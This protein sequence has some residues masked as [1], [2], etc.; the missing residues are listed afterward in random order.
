VSVGYSPKDIPSQVQKVQRPPPTLFHSASS[1]GRRR[2]SIFSPPINE[3]ISFKQVPPFPR[4]WEKTPLP[5]S[6]YLLRSSDL[7]GFLISAYDVLQAFSFSVTF[8]PFFPTP[9]SMPLS[10]FRRLNTGVGLTSAPFVAS[11]YSRRRQP[12][13]P[14][15]L[16]S[17]SHRKKVVSS[18]PS[19]PR[20]GTFLPI[21]VRWLPFFPL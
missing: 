15:G 1:Y 8:L 9:K 12:F 16:P 19:L 4:R 3:I 2:R 21:T 17:S 14:P 7:R 10:F 5:L 20:S 13:L 18:P 6:R 11:H